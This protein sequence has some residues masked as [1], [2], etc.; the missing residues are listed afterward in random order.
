MRILI[1]PDVHGN[2]NETISFIESHKDSVDKVVALGDY[3]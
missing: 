1:I 3:V 2:W